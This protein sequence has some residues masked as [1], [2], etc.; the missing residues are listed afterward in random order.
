MQSICR[1]LT[2]LCVILLI[3]APP[4]LG[5]SEQKKVALLV[6]VNR[7]D[8]RGF[9]D[10]PLAYAERDVDELAGLL[11]KQG[12][13]VQVLKGSSGGSPRA[14]KDNID[15]AIGKLLADRNARDIVLLGFAGHGQQLPLLDEDGG[16]K[17]DRNG[18]PLEDAYF[19]PVDAQ[20][21]NPQ[22]LIS[23]T[24][25]MERLDLRGESTCCWWTPAGTTRIRDAAGR[26]RG[27]NS[28]AGCRQTQRC[29]SV[30]RPD[31]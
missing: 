6:G 18:K 20:R 10:K 24:R 31:R 2:G 1:T 21:Q 19:C 29:C 12:Y 13:R 3:A 9:A 16:L 4:V 8:K 30:A 22:S 14:T 27:T 28:T 25:L 15:A 11:R 7:Y 26:S 23:L 5:Q 17:K